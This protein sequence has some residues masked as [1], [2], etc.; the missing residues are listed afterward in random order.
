MDFVSKSKNVSSCGW[1]IFNFKE[2]PAYKVHICQPNK[3]DSFELK[4]QKKKGLY[5][6][7]LAVL[8]IW[9]VIRKKNL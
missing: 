6:H 9:P 5:F 3:L 4:M 2:R 7:E 8:P 1:L